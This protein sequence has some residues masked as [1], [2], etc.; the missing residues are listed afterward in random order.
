MKLFKIIILAVLLGAVWGTATLNA[1]PT[2]QME[3]VETSI[4]EVKEEAN[5]ELP[6][7]KPIIVYHYY[8]DELVFIS[9]VTLT[10]YYFLLP[11]SKV[12]EDQYRELVYQ[13]FRVVELYKEI[14]IEPVVVHMD[15]ELL[16]GACA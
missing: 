13:I 4:H 7:A 11:A 1:E 3:A 15:S 2:V 10:G 8:K 5:T 12:L 9:G 16:I 6:T 14:G